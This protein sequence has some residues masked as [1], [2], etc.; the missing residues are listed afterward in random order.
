MA[1]HKLPVTQEEVLQLEKY[2]YELHR[3]TQTA[4]VMKDMETDKVHKLLIEVQYIQMALNIYSKLFPK[5]KA[6]IGYSIDETKKEHKYIKYWL[7]SSAESAGYILNEIPQRIELMCKG[8]RKTPVVKQS[9]RK[10]IRLENGN[11]R[12]ITQGWIFMYKEDW[13]KK[14]SQDFDL[15]FNPGSSCFKFKNIYEE[16]CVVK[17]DGAV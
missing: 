2:V 12:Y 9:L 4:E 6:V 10:P 14:G 17:T 15:V 16:Q 1:K 8:K 5:K 7:F 11:L 3:Y 13:D